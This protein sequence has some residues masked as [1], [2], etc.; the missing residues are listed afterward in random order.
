MCS[1]FQRRDKRN[2][3]ENFARIFSSYDV[4]G[5]DDNDAVYMCIYIYRNESSRTNLFW[6]FKKKKKKVFELARKFRKRDGDIFLE[7]ARRLFTVASILGRAFSRQY[8][9]YAILISAAPIIIYAD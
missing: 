8:F 1:P 3:A 9:V 4:V 2:F 7:S 5:F 6:I